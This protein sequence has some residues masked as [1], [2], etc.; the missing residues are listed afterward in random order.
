MKQNI[1]TQFLFTRVNC[2]NVICRS[3]FLYT[4]LENVNWNL[5][6]AK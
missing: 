4:M 2:F 1:P 5:C 6:D 3:T